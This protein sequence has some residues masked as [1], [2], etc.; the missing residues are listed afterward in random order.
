MT[1]LDIKTLKH[2]KTW[3]REKGERRNLKAD[4]VRRIGRNRNR[5]EFDI[6]RKIT[7]RHSPRQKRT[8]TSA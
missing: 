8:D 5:K 3:W 2:A 6:I 4:K 1:A 7:G